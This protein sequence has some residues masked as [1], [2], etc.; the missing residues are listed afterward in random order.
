[1]SDTVPLKL[2]T[3]NTIRTLYWDKETN[4]GYPI[5]YWN[6]QTDG[7]RDDDGNK[8]PRAKPE[9][10]S[11]VF[12]PNGNLIHVNAQENIH[13]VIEDW[14]SSSRSGPYKRVDTGQGC[15]PDY[16]YLT[17]FLNDEPDQCLQICSKPLNILSTNCINCTH[18]W[19]PK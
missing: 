12:I 10:I 14:L 9:H 6:A 5:H 1:M 16:Y 17:G 3:V 2:L 4:Q 7:G 15:R 11:H 8:P 19:I 13:E 18:C